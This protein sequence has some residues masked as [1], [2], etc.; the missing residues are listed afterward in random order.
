MT[1]I[2]WAV[3]HR[4][5][6]TNRLHVNLANGAKQCWQICGCSRGCGRARDAAWL[7]C[8]A[9]LLAGRAG[10]APQRTS[11]FYERWEFTRRVP[12]GYRLRSWEPNRFIP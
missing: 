5:V 2:S 7:A 9:E 6:L 1:D 4:G 3:L 12:G 10:P 11:G 8:E